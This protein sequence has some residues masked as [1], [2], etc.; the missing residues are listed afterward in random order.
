MA[1]SRSRMR[2][3]GAR[4]SPATKPATV[5]STARS[6]P[7]AGRWFG[8]GNTNLCGKMSLALSGDCPC[9]SGFRATPRCGKARGWRLVRDNSPYP[10]RPSRA[11]RQIYLLPLKAY[12]LSLKGNLFPETGL[13]ACA[14]FTHH[15]SMSESKTPSFTLDRS[16]FSVGRLQDED[17]QVDY[18]LSQTP[19]RRIAAVEFLR[20]SFNPDAYSAQRL[21][22]F[23]ETV[24]RT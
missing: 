2:N 14:A 19:E 5:S 8:C 9:I 17:S 13:A 4:R 7:W 1:R 16:A 18:W 24:K 22:G 3:S 11:W 21:H 12:I 10:S 23:F 6:A 15:F 20:R